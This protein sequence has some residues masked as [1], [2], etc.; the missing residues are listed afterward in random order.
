M[1]YE[2]IYLFLWLWTFALVIMTLLSIA[3]WVWLLVPWRRRPYVR[4][5]L[6]DGRLNWYA[7]GREPDTMRK[8][9]DA[10]VG[11]V[12]KDL[13]VCLRIYLK[14]PTR[15]AS[16]IAEMG[17]A[18]LFTPSQIDGAFMFYLVEFN[19]DRIVAVNVLHEI[20]ET[21]QKNF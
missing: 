15:N 13:G 11:E 6:C 17:H 19:A 7:A 14:P 21:L 1:Y 20:Y 2:K 12:Y 5:L 16:S 4:G 8:L 9:D 3:R 18:F 10:Y